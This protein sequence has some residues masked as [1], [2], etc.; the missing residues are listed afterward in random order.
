MFNAIRG[1]I[2]D[3]PNAL[4]DTSWKLSIFG[5]FLVRIFLHSEILRISLYSVQMRENTEHTKT[6]GTNF[7]F[8]NFYW[9]WYWLFLW[10]NFKEI[11]N[12]NLNK[13]EERKK[14][15]WG[16]QGSRLSK[17]TKFCQ[18]FRIQEEFKNHTVK[19]V[20]CKC[21]SSAKKNSEQFKEFQEFKNH[22]PPHGSKPDLSH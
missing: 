7:C 1:F 15:F 8:Y 12:T 17:R 18:K 3:S 6:N 13:A 16:F 4:W 22:W 19:D 20:F 2:L 14:F 10:N 9:G 5:V 11:I 21:I